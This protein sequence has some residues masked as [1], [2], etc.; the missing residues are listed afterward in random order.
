MK[1]KVSAGLKNPARV[2][3]GF[4]CPSAQIVRAPAPFTQMKY[5]FPGVT[6]KSNF[7]GSPTT[8]PLYLPVL[9]SRDTSTGGEVARTFSM[10]S[11]TML[12]YICEYPMMF[13]PAFSSTEVG[14]VNSPVSTKFVLAVAQM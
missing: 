2:S 8:Y 12:G 14:G 3:K 13:Q 6:R 1:N 4:A 7:A 10:T 9:V 5:A 11:L